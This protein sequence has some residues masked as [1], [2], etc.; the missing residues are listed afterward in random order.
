MVINEDTSSSWPRRLPNWLSVMRVQSV[1]CPASSGQLWQRYNPYPCWYKST[2]LLAKGRGRVIKEGLA[3]NPSPFFYCRIVSRDYPNS[4]NWPQ[5]RHSC[6]W[7]W[8]CSQLAVVSIYSTS[9]TFFLF[10]HTNKLY[11]L[12]CMRSISNSRIA[13]AVRGP[14]VCSM[15][16]L[17]F[18]V[19]W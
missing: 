13:I 14:S 5:I 3:T 2:I 15:L 19:M 11:L 6:S 9:S 12:T 8:T 10:S 17:N 1:I 16:N 7:C 4:A 18:H